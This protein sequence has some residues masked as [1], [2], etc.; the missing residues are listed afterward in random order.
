[1]AETTTR[2]HKLDATR[3]FYAAVGV[4]D[5]AVAFGRTA[6]SEAQTRFA[7]IDREPKALRDQAVTLVTGRVEDLNKGYTDL[8][9][10]GQHFVAKVR[11][12]EATQQT[13]A[14][15]KSTV[16][17]AKTTSTQAKNAAAATSDSATTTT[18][19]AAKKTTTTAKKAA[20][21]ATSSAKATGT[22]A[23]KTASAAARAATDGASKAGR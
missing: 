23:K 11:R 13:K 12:Q 10:R 9:A 18:K 7:K 5:L 16:T 3:P 20:K 1:M 14:A 19:A 22:S 8:A 6:A 2:Q 17:K 15:A 21:P 4:A